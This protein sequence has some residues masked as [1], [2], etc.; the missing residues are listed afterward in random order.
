MVNQHSHGKHPRQTYRATLYTETK[1]GLNQTPTISTIYTDGYYSG[2][3]VKYGISEIDNLGNESPIN[4]R[5]PY[6]KSITGHS[7]LNEIRVQ[8][9]PSIYR[10][11]FFFH[12]V[13]RIVLLHGF[14]KK[15][16]KTPMREIEIAEKRM[17]RF[18]EED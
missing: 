6:V 10:L 12:T 13:R 1:A 8:A 16:E 15:T 4:V 2:G 17:K 5:E 18:L 14:V 7:K 9:A 3:A 11:F